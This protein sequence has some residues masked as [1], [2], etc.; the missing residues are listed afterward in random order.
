MAKTAAAQ[1]QTQNINSEK[2][3]VMLLIRQI[4][5]FAVS[6]AIVIATVLLAFN[7]F[8]SELLRPVDPYDSAEIKIEIPMGSSLARIADILSRNDLIR[9]ELVFELFAEFTDQA[10]KLRAGEY[11][12][13]RDMNMQQIIDSLME[14]KAM[15]DVVRFRIP[16]GYTIKEM[17]ILFDTMTSQDGDK[18]FEFTAQD[19]IDSAKDMD[20]YIDDFPFLEYI[21]Q[22]RREGQFP[23]EGYLFP[24]TYEAYSDAS[25]EDV[26]RLMLRTFGRKVYDREF[27]E[28]TLADRANRLD[29]TI[30]EVLVLASIIQ[31]E[32]G[33]DEFHKVSAVFHNRLSI[34][35]LLQSC[36]T[37]LYLIPRDEWLG[38]YATDAQIEA[39]KDSKYNTYKHIGLPLGP[40]S[41]PSQLAVEAALFPYEQFMPPQSRM[42]FFVYRGDGTHAFNETYEEHRRDVERFEDLW[43]RN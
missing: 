14:G 7:I 23:L 8:Y 20:R 37:V 4:S 29:M 13:S 32:A 9:N 24:D 42:L 1:K 3:L 16:E 25:P 18:K 34:D 12:L 43:R 17:A 41:A 30:D 2:R 21:P 38:P 31:A 10:H 19:F 35:M 6:L 5:V 28:T 11:L 33:Y 26:I 22:E 15:P 36:S 39:T 40:I 27:N